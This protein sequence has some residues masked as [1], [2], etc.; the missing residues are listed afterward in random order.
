MRHTSIGQKARIVTFLKWLC[1]FVILFVLYIFQTTPGFM[2]VMGIKPILILPFVI[3]VVVFEGE[4]YGAIFG[5]IGGLFLDISMGRLFGFFGLFLLVFCCLIG[6]L[7]IYLIRQNMVNTILITA[8]AMAI[9]LLLDYYFNFAM[10]GYEHTHII[11]LKRILPTFC[12]SIIFSPLFYL[13]VKR[14]FKEA[15]KHLD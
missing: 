4:F 12:Y 14:I 11:L 15:Q 1:Y 8:L 10:W 9:I 7:I 2:Q 6:L 5:A 3:S 13:L